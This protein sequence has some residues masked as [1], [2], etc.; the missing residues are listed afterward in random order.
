MMRTCGSCAR[1]APVPGRT[2]RIACGAPYEEGGKKPTWARR[3]DLLEKWSKRK[4]TERFDM[5]AGH[6]GDRCELWLP[7]ATAGHA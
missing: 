4:E 2:N 5:M 3:K 7:Q 1:G 6:D